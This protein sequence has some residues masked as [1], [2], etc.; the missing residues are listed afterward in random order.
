MGLFS[1]VVISD[2][3]EKNPKLNRDASHGEAVSILILE[4]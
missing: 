3:S 4:I 2:V 1:S